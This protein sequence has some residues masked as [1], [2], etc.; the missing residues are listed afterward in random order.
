LPPFAVVVGA[1]LIACT[2]RAPAQPDAVYRVRGAIVAVD[3]KGS[4][5][6]AVIAHEAIPEFADRSGTKAGMPAM[7]MAF[8]VAPGVDV[9]A[10]VPGSQWL[11]TFEVHWREEPALRIVAA[12]PLPPG[13]QLVLPADAQ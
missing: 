5:L 8:A 11:L 7:K 9:S 1:L 12:R 10:L 13:T 2:E 3:G 6:R 4:D